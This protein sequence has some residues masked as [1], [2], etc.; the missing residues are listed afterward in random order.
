M[1][2]NGQT[3]TESMDSPLV[4]FDDLENSPCHQFIGKGNQVRWGN[5]ILRSGLLVDPDRWIVDAQL[6]D[7]FIVSVAIPNNT[8]CREVA[9][10]RAEVLSRDG[11]VLVETP[12]ATE[13]R[14]SI[15][16]DIIMAI[17]V[18]AAID[19]PKCA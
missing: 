18:T 2:Q 8:N 9:G 12:G 7:Q 3:E 11:L 14:H 6:G 16:W 5:A 10:E 1:D 19:S 17:E 15:P 13:I 4:E